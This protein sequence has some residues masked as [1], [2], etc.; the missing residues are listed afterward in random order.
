MGSPD[1]TGD[2]DEHPMHQVTLSAYCIDQTEVTVKAYV[3]CVADKGCPPALFSEAA[4]EYG[5]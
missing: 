1:G 3:A 2:P 4:D 5:T